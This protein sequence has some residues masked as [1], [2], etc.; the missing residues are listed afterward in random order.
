MTRKTSIIPAARIGEA[1]LWIR[2]EKVILDRDLAVLYGVQT[3]AI[4]QAVKRNVERFPADF[5]FQLSRDEWKA[6]R[7][8]GVTSKGRGGRRYPP[9]AFT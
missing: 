7:S 2:D 1:I 8:Q 3:K 4:T 9:Y 6:L 5:M